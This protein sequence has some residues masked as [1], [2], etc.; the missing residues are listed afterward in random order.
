M[1]GF[2]GKAK[3]EITIVAKEGLASFFLV[4]LGLVGGVSGGLLVRHL[5][6]QLKLIEALMINH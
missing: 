2:V 5:L 4:I 6:F 3:R 1:P